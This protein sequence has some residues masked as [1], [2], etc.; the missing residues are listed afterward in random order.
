[1]DRPDGLS[2]MADRIVALEAALAAAPKVTVTD[3]WAVVDKSGN[4]VSTESSN[5]KE[6][7]VWHNVNYSD[8]APHTVRRVALLEDNNNNN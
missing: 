4:I 3:R 6:A 2:A 1:M 5:D 7:V 8:T